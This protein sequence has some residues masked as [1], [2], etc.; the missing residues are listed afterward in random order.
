MTS[1]GNYDF[2]DQGGMCSLCIIFSWPY[3]F[4]ILLPE[5]VAEAQQKVLWPRRQRNVDRETGDHTAAASPRPLG[6]RPSGA[7]MSHHTPSP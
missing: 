1:L 3:L 2:K 6:Y 7:A 5:G 4:N